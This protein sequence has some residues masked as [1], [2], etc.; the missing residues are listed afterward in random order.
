M[1]SKWLIGHWVTV[2][3]SAFDVAYDVEDETTKLSPGVSGTKH[4]GFPVPYFWLFWGMRF[5][6]IHKLY[7]YALHM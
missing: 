7:P 4:G 2:N 5:Y 3:V 6:L 1:S